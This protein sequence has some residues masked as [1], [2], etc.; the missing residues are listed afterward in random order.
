MCEYMYVCMYVYMYV[1]I[2][3]NEGN[4]TGFFFYFFFCLMSINQ[5]KGIY[6]NPLILLS[7]FVL[8]IKLSYTL[9]ESTLNAERGGI[10]KVGIR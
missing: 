8:E 7:F 1:C 2:A 6:I 3:P 9:Y 5:I 4:I 10:Y